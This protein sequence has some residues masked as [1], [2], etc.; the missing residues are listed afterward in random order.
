MLAKC[1]TLVLHSDEITLCLGLDNT[2]RPLDPIN[3]TVLCLSVCDRMWGIGCSQKYN[4]ARIISLSYQTSKIICSLP[5]LARKFD[6]NLSLSTN[7]K[8]RHVHRSRENK[9]DLK[10]NVQ[11]NTNYQL[12]NLLK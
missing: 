11:N 6:V 12:A 3:S 10:V 8:A 2:D 7:R 5:T 4:G 1:V 9:Y